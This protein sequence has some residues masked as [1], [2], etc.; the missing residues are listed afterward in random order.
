MKETVMMP[1]ANC[2]KC[3]GRGFE[4][5]NLSMGKPQPCTCLRKKEIEVPEPVS[6]KEAVK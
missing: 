4:G 3:H 5:M 2:K 6:P 1:K